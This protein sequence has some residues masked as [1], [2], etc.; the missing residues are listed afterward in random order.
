MSTA[1]KVLSVLILLASLGWIFLGAGVAQLNRGW[2]EK[3]AKLADELEKAE[4][5]LLKAQADL[6]LVKDQ[7][8][9]F[10]KGMDAKVAVI[11]ARM[12]DVEAANS[13]LKS[14][15]N[16]MQAQLGT[17]ES[18]VA[19]ARH[20][21]E[22][23]KQEK[24]TESNLLADSRTEVLRLRGVDDELSKRLADLRDTFKKTFDY[25]VGSVGGSTH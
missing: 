5:G 19:Q 13:R 9:N 11:R 8:A 1:G 15:L 4:V 14:I 22:V 20:D 18:T 25:N 7:T 6:I 24:E 21:L 23:R 10:Q 17:M 12:G 16:N 2:N 3:L